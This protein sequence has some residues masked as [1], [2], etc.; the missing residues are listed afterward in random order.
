MNRELSYNLLKFALS[1]EK[2]NFDVF[3]GPYE[4]ISP[5]DIL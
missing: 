4:P 5:E 1:D 2:V 3:K